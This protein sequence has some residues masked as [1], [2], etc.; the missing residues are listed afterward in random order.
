MVWEETVKGAD[1]VHGHVAIVER[2]ERLDDGRLRVWYTDNRNQD[3]ANPSH[4]DIRPGEAGIS[5]IYDKRP[6]S[7]PA[8]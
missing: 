3:A 5:F 4:R 8:M 6:G 2:V 1:P 7:T